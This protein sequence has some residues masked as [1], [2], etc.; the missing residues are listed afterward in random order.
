MQTVDMFRSS[1]GAA[2]LAT[3]DCLR[4]IILGSHDDLEESIKWNAPNF[5][6]KGRDRITLG[7]ERKGGVRAVFHL[8]AKVADNSGFRFDDKTGLARWP[9]TDRGI[10]IFSDRESVEARRDEFADLCKRWLQATCR[11]GI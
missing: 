6:L 3:V 2:D 11:I 9:A 5:S 4:E 1:L 7:L 10:A 8:G